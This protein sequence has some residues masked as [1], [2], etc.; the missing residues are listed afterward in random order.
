MD[1]FTSVAMTVVFHANGTVMTS[2]FEALV[3]RG[4][5]QFGCEKI[6]FHPCGPTEVLVKIQSASIS[7][8]S[9]RNMYIG[10]PRYSYPLLLGHEPCGV[11][12][13]KGSEV[14]HL[15]VGDRVTWWFSLGS[16][17]DYCYTDTTQV[18][19]AKL[20]GEFDIAAAS[21]LELSVAVACGV[22][23]AN[24]TPNQRVLVIGLGPSGL[25][26]TQQFKLKGVTDIDDWEVLSKRSQWGRKFGLQN[27]FNPTASTAELETHVGAVD[28]YDLVIDCY[29]DDLRPDGQTINAALK[30]LKNGGTLI[31]YGHPLTPRS[32]DMDLVAQKNINLFEAAM[33]MSVVQPLVEEQIEL[34][35]SGKLDLTSMVTHRIKLHE[36]EAT[37]LDQ[38]ANPDDY[39]KAVFDM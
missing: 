1:C 16:F 29:C 3:A 18:G 37:L 20:T 21:I 17:P 13:E 25:L 15:D 12:T 27:T 14:Q 36:V 5:R 9:D 35:L 19:I 4:P 32:V 34:F 30:V 33:P 2:T 23:A 7:N 39:I 22:Y 6:P 11:I 10:H 8:G 24:V 26:F 31:K 38:I 28:P